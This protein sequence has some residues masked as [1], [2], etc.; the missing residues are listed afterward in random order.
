MS[1]SVDTNLA[2]ARVVHSALT[3]LMCSPSRS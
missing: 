2:S 1:L 3:P